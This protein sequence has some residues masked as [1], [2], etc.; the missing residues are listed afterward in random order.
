MINYWYLTG[1][2][3][4]N[5]VTQQAMLHQA[6][7]TEDY[8]PPN[9]T[10]TEGNDDQGFWGLSAMRAAETKFQDPP[11]TQPGW[12][13]LAQGVFRTQAERWDPANC[14]GGLRWQIFVWNKGYK[15]KNSIS[16]GCFFTLAAR[17]ALYTG[18]PM[19]SDWAIKTW[20]WVNSVGLMTPDFKVYDGTQID[21]NCKTQDRTRWTYNAGVFLLGSAAMYNHVS[22]SPHRPAC[23]Y[24]PSGN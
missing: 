22:H 15:Y 6:S 9:Q 19:Y 18:N 16:N 11:S 13:A 8:M 14:N 1:D 21:S 24:I 17:L 5:E 4:Y 7:S 2:T 3:T 10:S 12:L 23:A 20:D